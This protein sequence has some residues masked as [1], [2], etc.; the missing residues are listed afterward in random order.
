MANNRSYIDP[1]TAEVL[2]FKHSD[3]LNGWFP[4]VTDMDDILAGTTRL[5]RTTDTDQFVTISEGD[6]RFW[7]QLSITEEPDIRALIAHPWIT[8]GSYVEGITSAEVAAAETL[9][10]G[11]AT[12]TYTGFNT[13]DLSVTLESALRP[14]L[15]WPALD[16]TLIMIPS[17]RIVYGESE[18]SMSQS[19]S[20]PLPLPKH[21]AALVIDKAISEGTQCPITM[22]TLTAETA[23]VTSC[24]HVF[25]AEALR[26]WLT[27]R[28]TCPE[29]RQVAVA[30][31]PKEH[32]D[33]KPK[34][35]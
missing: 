2:L 1:Q 33:H 7:P 3:E 28:G 24:G 16:P 19:Q 8:D 15:D 30:T 4:A 31:E 9:Y 34:S 11:L 27:A 14:L 10:R 35:P 32:G 22:E 21:V 12:D 18:S 26:T 23:A 17:V 20:H 13:S 25:Q 29:C 6:M 5:Y